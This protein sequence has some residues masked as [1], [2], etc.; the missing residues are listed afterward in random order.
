VGTAQAE[1]AS[2]RDGD[3][4]ADRVGAAAGLKV[5]EVKRLVLGLDGVE[6]HQVEATDRVCQRTRRT[7]KRRPAPHDSGCCQAVAPPPWRSCRARSAR[8][9]HPGRDRRQSRTQTSALCFSAKA[10]G[11]SDAPHMWHPDGESCI[12]ARAPGASV[13]Q[14]AA[15]VGWDARV[16][17][18]QNGSTPP[19]SAGF[20][21]R[22]E[23]QNRRQTGEAEQIDQSSTHYHEQ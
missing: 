14:S 3:R 6:A 20:I 23:L 15:A 11:R 4:A 8:P 21:D 13:E 17:Y 22:L 10:R 1:A 18:F 5:A 2:L 9:K 12:E 19:R 16:H 7:W